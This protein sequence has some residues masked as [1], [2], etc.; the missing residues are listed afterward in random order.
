VVNEYFEVHNY[1]G[2]YIINGSIMPADPGVKPSLTI[3]ALAEYA[4]SK[5]E[6]KRYTSRQVNKVDG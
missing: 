4:M 3:T 2:I 1:P 5:V 6:S